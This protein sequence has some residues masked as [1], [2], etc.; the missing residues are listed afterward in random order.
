MPKRLVNGR[1]P[2]TPIEK[3]RVIVWRQSRAFLDSSFLAKTLVQFS[4]VAF[5]NNVATVYRITEDLS[6][7]TFELIAASGIVSCLRLFYF[8]FESLSEKG[9]ERMLPNKNK[10]HGG[11]PWSERDF[12]GQLKLKIMKTQPGPEVFFD[13]SQPRQKERSK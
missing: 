7:R 10:D 1:I 8:S 3:A 13:H 5:C 9:R 12:S 6:I 4:V 11:E 2:P